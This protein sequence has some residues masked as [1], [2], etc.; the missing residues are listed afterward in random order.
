MYKMLFYN[1][2]HMK[3]T[4]TISV[5]EELKNEFF[6]FSKELGTNPTNLM[7][8]FMKDSVR[9]RKIE[10][11]APAHFDLEIEAFSEEEMQSF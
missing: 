9:K 6:T 1:N 8:M 4:M 2:F 3:T 7:N 5:E 11:S 10:F